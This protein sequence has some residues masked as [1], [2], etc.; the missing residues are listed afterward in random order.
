[1]IATCR[2]CSVRMSVDWLGE[3]AR[4]FRFVSSEISKTMLFS[5]DLPLLTSLPTS[6]CSR[7]GMGKE[8]S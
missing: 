1:M 2:Y 7:D 3:L 4:R 5:V 8:R 6:S